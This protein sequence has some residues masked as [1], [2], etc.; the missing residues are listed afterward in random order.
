MPLYSFRCEEHD[1]VFDEHHGMSTY[2]R[3]TVCPDH[4]CDAHIV[5]SRT[6]MPQFN[7]DNTDRHF[8]L[9]AGQR[10]SSR[11]DRRVWMKDND[12]VE[13]CP[14]DGWKA[15]AEMAEYREMRAEGKLL[16]SPKQRAAQ[17]EAM[18]PVSYGAC[19]DTLPGTDG[20]CQI[21]VQVAVA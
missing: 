3:N 16:M 7:I 21:D 19:E 2:P 20:A 5:I 12:V 9:G 15:K 14:E 10:F 4:G 13:I 17:A 6:N 11:A 1:H 8:D 18:L